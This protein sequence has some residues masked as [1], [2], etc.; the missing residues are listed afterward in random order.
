LYFERKNCMWG[1]TKEVHAMLITFNS[2]DYDIGFVDTVMAAW[3]GTNMN[4]L[5]VFAGVDSDRTVNWVKV[6]SWLDDTTLHAYIQDWLHGKKLD[7]IK[8]ADFMDPLMAKHWNR[9]DFKKDFSY[10]KLEIPTWLSVTH[11]IVQ[12]VSFIVFALVYIFLGWSRAGDNFNR[13]FGRRR[14]GYYGNGYRDKWR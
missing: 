14:Y 8:L 6:E 7:P 9:K 2:K 11:A 10:I 12:T 4:E 5:C 3:R 13:I 1:P